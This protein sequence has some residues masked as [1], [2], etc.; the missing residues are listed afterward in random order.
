MLRIVA[1]IF[2]IL[3]WVWSWFVLNEIDDLDHEP[4]VA[5]FFFLVWTCPIVSVL[6]LFFG[7]WLGLYCK[8]RGLEEQKKI[9]ALLDAE[10]A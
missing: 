2:N 1:V 6:A 10:D 9:D 7:G 8:R 5:I 3:L 4:G